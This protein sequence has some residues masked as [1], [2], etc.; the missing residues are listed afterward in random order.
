MEAA[1][2]I[3]SIF[4]ENPT[5]TASGSKQQALNVVPFI[6]ADFNLSNPEISLPKISVTEVT[7]DNQS[8]LAACQITRDLLEG[9]EGTNEKY[10]KFLG[11]G[12]SRYSLELIEDLGVDFTTEVPFEA[13]RQLLT[14]YNKELEALI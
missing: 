4:E 14:S 10:L 8:I 3:P 11:A 6:L 12:S 2:Q 9:V 1:A 5:F 7:S 13:A